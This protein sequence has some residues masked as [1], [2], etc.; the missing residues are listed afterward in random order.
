MPPDPSEIRNDIL[1]LA[2]Y[3][4]NLTAKRFHREVIGL[5]DG[6]LEALKNYYFPGN[7]RELENII[8]HAVALTS[9][10]TI[11][12]K[13]LP[14]DLSEIDIFSFEQS[15]N[16]VMTLKALEHPMADKKTSYPEDTTMAGWWRI[17]W[18]WYAVGD[19]RTQIDP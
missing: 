3:F 6:A 9:D 13:D 1:L 14:T 16:D 4:L 19:Q 2:N 11:Q 8:E 12:L 17:D 7:V 15:D 10:D 5:S 18:P